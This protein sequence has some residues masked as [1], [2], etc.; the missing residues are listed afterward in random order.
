MDQV[1]VSKRR[2]EA[3]VPLNNTSDSETVFFILFFIHELITNYYQLLVVMSATFFCRLLLRESSAGHLC[4]SAGW[5]VSTFADFYHPF[6]EFTWSSA[7]C[8][9]KL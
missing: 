6:F 1:C 2:N 3:C 8:L 5:S 4:L 9:Q 7:P